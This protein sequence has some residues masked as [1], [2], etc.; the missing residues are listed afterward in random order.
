MLMQHKSLL[1]TLYLHVLV[2]VPKILTVLFNRSKDESSLEAH[3]KN[4]VY[5]EN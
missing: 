4:K 5:L 3:N 2:N 1:T